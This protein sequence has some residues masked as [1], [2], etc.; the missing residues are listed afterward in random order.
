[1]SQ[2]KFSSEEQDLAREAGNLYDNARN[3]AS[4][5]AR[6]GLKYMLLRL[7]L[8]GLSDHDQKQLRKL[9]RLVFADADGAQEEAG[10]EAERI[11]SR[12]TA[13][14]LAVAITNIVSSASEKK[15]AMLGAVF[16]AYAGHGRNIAS[17]ILGAVAG[18][19]AFSTNDLLQQHL[20]MKR[21]LE[22]E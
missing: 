3:F 18:V 2:T 1:M 12:K 20:E 22:A 6:L 9:A 14:P 5:D 8:L 7:S 10:Q 17:G 15:M 19:V 16:G 13:S 4:E 21:F 11:R